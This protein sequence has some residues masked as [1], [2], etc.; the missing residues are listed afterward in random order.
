MGL[1][2]NMRKL[3]VQ[4]SSSLSLKYT[5]SQDDGTCRQHAQ[6]GGSNQLIY[7]S[8]LNIHCHE[9][10]GLVG[11]MHKL[12][13]QVSSSLSLKC[14]LSQDDGTIVGNMRKLEVQGSS[15]PSLKCTLSRD[16]LPRV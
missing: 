3:E 5:L 8:L 12:E 14:A 11:N 16:F 2:G 9:M 4:V 6:A 7:L 13:V 1:V 10:M 15:S